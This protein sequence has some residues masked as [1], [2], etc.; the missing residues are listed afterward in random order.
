MGCR[1]Q[2]RE[3]KEEYQQP[4]P[5]GQFETVVKTEATYQN[6]SSEVD[7][8][9]QWEVGWFKKVQDIDCRAP[10]AK[11]LFSLGTSHMAGGL[12]TNETI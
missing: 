7:L 8:E 3:P 9:T 4:N 5:R 2:G 12:A 1:S 10:G 11:A 6:L